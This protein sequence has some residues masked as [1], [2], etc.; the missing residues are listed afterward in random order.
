VS[1]YWQPGTEIMWRWGGWG[2]ATWAEPMRVIR[3]DERGLVAW[4]PSGTPVLSVRRSDGGELRADKA[5]MFTDPWIQ[6]QTVWRNNALRI[7]PPGKRW[8]VW[9]LFDDQSGEFGGWYVNI[10]DVHTRDATGVDTK[11]NVLD[12]VVAPDRSHRRKDEDELILAVEHGRYTQAQ[13]DEITAVAD[14]IEHIIRDWGSPFCDGWEEFRADPEWPLPTLQK[15]LPELQ[16]PLPELQKL[17]QEQR[18]QY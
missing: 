8:S 11:D 13:A 12:V 7:A 16:K 17:D 3:D 5:T 18:T 1:G 9:L 4:L 14:E 2:P 10:E 6:I 15:P